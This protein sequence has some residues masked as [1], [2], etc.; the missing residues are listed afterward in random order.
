MKILISG[1]SG[2]IGQ[3]VERSLLKQ[4]HQVIPLKRET[5]TEEM[6]CWNIENGVIDL[7]KHQEIDIVIHFAGESIAEGRWNQQKKERIKNS[8]IKGTKLLSEYFSKTSYKPKLFVS[9]SAIGFYGNRD[10]EELSENSKKGA[11]FLSDV[12]AQ[13]EEATSKLSQAGVRVSN[14]RLGMVLSS[15]GGALQ[16]ML[17]PFKICFGGIVGDG[18]QY[19]SWVT[20]DDVVGI[21]NHIIESETLSGAINVVSPNPVTNHTFTKALGK[22]LNR[23]TLFPLPAFM[24]KI[25]FGE[26]AQ[27]LLLSS[28]KV[29]PEKLQKHGYSFK[30]PL[31]KNALKDIVTQ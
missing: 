16:K 22:A 11:G 9:G 15:K 17:L 23:P 25:I 4:G 6:P 14:I 13:W 7:G 19:I 12:C 21:V 20:I 29:V 27:E 30:Y 31:L 1:A 5:T 2:L 18:K 10:N 28:T 8:R 3:E 24:A 26:M